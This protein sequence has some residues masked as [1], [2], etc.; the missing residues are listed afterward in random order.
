[1]TFE[2]IPGRMAKLGVDRAWL[3][4]QCDYTPDS[5]RQILAPRGKGK[6]DKALRRIWEALDREEERQ[7]TP[8]LPQPLS[9]RVYLEPTSAEFDRWMA[10]AYRVPGRT[11][12]QWAREG[13][14]AIAASELDQ[15]RGLR[16]ADAADGPAATDRQPVKYST[17]RKTSGSKP[18]LVPPPASPPG[19]KEA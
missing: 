8:A 7:S 14:D 12:D 18:K 19:K 6:T 5:L 11:F 17:G 9:H 3:A 4:A 2:E 13:L 16:V 1:M 10:A 15:L